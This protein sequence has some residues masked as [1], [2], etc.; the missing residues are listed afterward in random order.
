MKETIYS[1]RFANGVIKQAAFNEKEAEILA[2]AEAIKRG[3]DYRIVKEEIQH[4]DFFMDWAKL[5]P[6]ESIK[7]R[8]LLAKAQATDIYKEEK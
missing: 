7:L 4:M 6:D 2:K 5:T 8:Q 3:W 1:F